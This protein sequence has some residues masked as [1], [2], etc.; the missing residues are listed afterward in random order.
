M[1]SKETENALPVAV[2][3][4]ALPLE[5]LAVEAYLDDIKEDKAEDGTIYGKGVLRSEGQE[6][7]VVI[8]EIGEGNTRAS[9]E[10]NLAFERYRPDVM[11]F[12]GIAGS[13]K[14]ASIGDVVVATKVYFCESGKGEE[15][16]RPR[17]DLSQPTYAALEQAK[18]EAKKNDWL[19]LLHN[20][21]CSVPGKRP[22]Y[23][24]VY[25]KPIASV[26]QVIGSS[27]A[28]MIQRIKAHYN[29][30][31]AVEMEGFGFLQSCHQHPEM[32]SLV[33]R[34]ISDLLDDKA[35]TDEQG[36]QEIAAASA[37]A[38]TFQV[39]CSL[40][41]QRQRKKEYL[42][43]VRAPEEKD[44]TTRNEGIHVAKESKS[45]RK[46]PE[47]LPVVDR[48]RKELK[49]RG[50]YNIG[51]EERV[52]LFVLAGSLLPANVKFRELHNHVLHK[53]YLN[54]DN[55][56]L[57]A[58]EKCLIYTT[59][60]RDT[61]DRK[62]GWFWLRRLHSKRIVELL[63]HDA[64][65]NTGDNESRK[66]AI[67]ILQMLAPSKAEV[68]LVKIV[69]DCDH[70]QKR[71]ILDYLCAHGSGK[72]MNVVEELTVDQHEGVT[73]KAI[74]AKIGI[75]SRCDPAQAVKILVE[76]ATKKSKICEEPA[77]E[78][79]V[80][81]MNTRNLRK[82]S[83]NNYIYALKELAKRGKATEAEL[84]RILESD[85]P[86]IRFLGY[87]GLL[88]Q[89]SVFNPV[90]IRN[91]WPKKH[92]TR[93]FSLLG[94]Y[95]ETQGEN[96]FEKTL[97]EAYLKMPISELEGSVELKYKRGIAY[98]AWGLSGGYSV[99]E[100]IRNDIKNNFKKH[101]VNLL[102]GI[103]E[104]IKRDTAGNQQRKESLQNSERSMTIELTVSALKVLKKYG[105]ASD[106]LIAKI[107]LKSADAKVRAAAADLFTK[108][109]GKRDID[110][111]SEIASSG[112]IE[113]RIV[114]A[115]RI[116][117]LDT[118]KKLS[119]DLLESSYSDVFKEVICCYIANKE[120]LDWSE[121]STLFC[122]KNDEIRLLAIAYAVKTWTR[123]K[124]VLL[125][126]R[127][128]S[129]E[130][131]YY[132]VVCWLDRVLYAPGDLAQGYKKKL[133]ERFN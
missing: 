74:L 3:L 101:K 97:L 49:K 50:I 15:D 82:L 19:F 108:Y 128:L 112:D 2:I 65:S 31:I 59:L 93:V 102:A 64:V 133:I 122:S 90:E 99:V 80:S 17:P 5:Y 58:N 37:A 111:L 41:L 107:F 34:G 60:L 43:E 61:W 6:L 8:R 23:H 119:R 113:C 131:Y 47:A 29:D 86:E 52:R 115:K 94:S 73:S 27:D 83:V 51:V 62:T 66:G 1:P 24:K 18:A 56:A 106:K 87:S 121:M 71:N 13:I 132:D 30:A 126:K 57:T 42:A 109:A 114:A 110:V 127:Y 63:E 20:K 123:Q 45:S 28:A 120:I 95:H 69:K 11:L 55:E 26:A 77:L 72:S 54:R 103:E 78:K 75:L 9:S 35:Q 7:I 21:L 118:G 96:W 4:T 32:Y 104:E 116:L 44:E 38:F 117:K 85:I 39:L 70:V 16:F 91:N 98:L 130:T 92:V 100:V 68:S 36:N 33:V 14:D 67:R 88:K 76:E 129:G 81:T 46:I 84:K 48:F 25:I 89:G 53:M 124:L 105:N 40:D 10:V 125:L 22:R 12:C 79:I